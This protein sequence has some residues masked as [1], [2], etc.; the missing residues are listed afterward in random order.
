MFFIKQVSVPKKVIGIRSSTKVRT[1][2]IEGSQAME[3]LVEVPQPIF[4]IE[5][6]I[7][8]QRILRKQQSTV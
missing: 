8:T 3:E 4:K 2:K 1:K 6:R 7:Y 5:Q